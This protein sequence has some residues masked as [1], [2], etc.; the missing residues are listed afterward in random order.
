MCSCFFMGGRNSRNICIPCCSAYALDRNRSPA[1]RPPG[2]PFCSLF[3]HYFYGLAKIQHGPAFFLAC[4]SFLYTLE[5]CMHRQLSCLFLAFSSDRP[6]FFWHSLLYLQDTHLSCT[7]RETLTPL[8]HLAFFWQTNWLLPV[9]YFFAFSALNPL[10]F[11]FP[12]AML[13]VHLG[14]GHSSPLEQGEHV[15]HALR[16]PSEVRISVW[17]VN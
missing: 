6:A 5:N 9:F 17:L 11:G 16:T 4:R 14:L 12:N 13:S 2:L 7:L 10:L 15:Q 1:A 3:R 8:C